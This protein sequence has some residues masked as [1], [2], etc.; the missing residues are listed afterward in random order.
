MLRASV[1]EVQCLKTKY[2]GVVNTSNTDRADS[3]R[4]L[5]RYATPQ[6]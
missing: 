6:S 2:G 5:F 1:L 3:L 4:A